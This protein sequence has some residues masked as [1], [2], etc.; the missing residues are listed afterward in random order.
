MAFQSFAWINGLDN[1]DN[2]VNVESD[3]LVYQGN[4]IMVFA[5]PI[6]E[7]EQFERANRHITML[8]NQVAKWRITAAHLSQY[9]D[10]R[11]S[12]CNG[13]YSADMTIYTQ[14]NDYTWNYYSVTM[15]LP[16]ESGIEF[17]PGNGLLNFEITFAII[18]EVFATP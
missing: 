14:A 10:I 17:V 13:G 6:D 3:I 4:P 11:T 9:W 2:V 7:G 16:K 8:G 5:P 18:E 1:A 12:Y 15:Q